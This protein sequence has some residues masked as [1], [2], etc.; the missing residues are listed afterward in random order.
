MKNEKV[1]SNLDEINLEQLGSDEAR[2]PIPE[3]Y[4]NEAI[5]FYRK[6]KWFNRVGRVAEKV[7]LTKN[8]KKLYNKAIDYYEKAE[9]FD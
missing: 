3:N 9:K 2:A 6:A 4:L 7:R 5:K 8:A 1:T